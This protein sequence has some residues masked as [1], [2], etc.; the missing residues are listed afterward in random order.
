MSGED[1]FSFCRLLFCLVDPVIY[2]I[3]LLRF[4]R[5]HLLIFALSVCAT[6]VIFKKS[7]PLPM[8]SSV[9]IFYEV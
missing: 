8:C 2:F 4:R 9:H 6:G 1:L 3:G 7:S 5:F